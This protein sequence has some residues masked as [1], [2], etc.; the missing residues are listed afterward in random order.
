MFYQTELFGHAEQQVQDL[1]PVKEIQ[2]KENIFQ[3][4]PLFDKE[5]QN[6]LNTVQMSLF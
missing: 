1:E 3:D 5:K 2:Q 6:E 4:L